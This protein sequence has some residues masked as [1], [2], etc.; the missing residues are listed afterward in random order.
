MENFIEEDV[1][2]KKNLQPDLSQST[3]VSPDFQTPFENIALAFSGGGFRA[4][5]YTLGVLSYL[6]SITFN[7]H[8]NSLEPYSLLEKVKFIS[9]ASGGTVTAALYALSCAEQITFEEFYRSS[10]NTLTGDQILV[11][12]LEI[13]NDDAIW[14]TRKDKARNI[15]NA[16]ALCYD[17]KLFNGKLMETLLPKNKTKQTHLEEVCFNTTEFYNGIPFRQNM[18][19]QA[20]APVNPGNNFYF[21]NY[22]LQ[23]QLQTSLMLRLSDVLAASSCFPGGFEPLKFPDDFTY[24]G[25]NKKSL[26]DA[27]IANPATE[28]PKKVAL[29]KENGL[30]LMDG[31]VTDNQGLESLML[32]DLRRQEKNSPFKRFDLMLVNDVGSQYMD[33]FVIPKTAKPNFWNSISYRAFKVIFCIIAVLTG[34]LIVEGWKLPKSHHQSLLLITGGILLS[35]LLILL[36]VHLWVRGKIYDTGESKSTLNL[37]KNFS[38]E[39]IDTLLDYFEKT[40]LY[41]ISQML[42]T[43]FNSVLTLNSD[44]FLK[45]IRQLIYN[46]FYNTPTWE[47]RGKGNHV[48]DLATVNNLNRLNHTDTSTPALNSPA[49][50]TVAQ[51]AYE[52]PTTL[53]FDKSNSKTVQSLACLIAC[54]QFTTC[55]NLLE[56]SNRLLANTAL[57]AKIKVNDEKENY[58]NR[59]QT[60]HDQL[61]NDWI[62]FQQD[63]F[64]FFNRITPD[65]FKVEGSLI[66][67]I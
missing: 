21:G 11:R 18:I 55:Y 43:R 66:K 50:Q 57:L 53:W 25:V 40:P 16:F 39:V 3:T 29:M 30:A 23:L 61:Y 36:F 62:D 27:L 26:M 34:S 32:A 41:V 67:G 13:L 7:D 28:D 64:Y 22:T 17:E 44:V 37:S 1:L 49:I 9:S 8:T 35:V 5:S 38:P 65:H 24:D 31:G 2:P 52:M 51:I 14:K 19:V 12:A 46:R 33:S 63:P 42:K 47:N 10:Y 56:Y 4:A 45:R 15:I 48:Y 58:K 54:G 60:I 59:I 6:N 20:G